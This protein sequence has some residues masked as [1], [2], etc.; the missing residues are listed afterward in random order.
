M[1]K[2]NIK[3]G[4]RFQSNTG[5][6]C[7]VIKYNNCNDVLIK[8]DAGDYAN[9]QTSNLIRGR[10]KSAY[11]KSVYGIGYVGEG[12][13]PP[14][15]DGKRTKLY[16]VWFNMFNRCYNPETHSRQPTYIGCTVCPRWHNY[17][18]F[19]ADAHYLD[20]FEQWYENDIPHA[21]ALDKD[22]IK[23][24]NKEYGPDVCK[25]V[26]SAENNAARMAY[27]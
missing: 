3:V 14:V 22:I 27:L 2:H 4:D 26:T 9:V 25:F 1:T 21:W 19:A 18:H 11:D 16:M 6:W 10:I 13:F 7:E 8:F 12:I 23:P 20:G 15:V 5:M 24:G 17:Q